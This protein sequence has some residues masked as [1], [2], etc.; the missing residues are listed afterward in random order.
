M[1]KDIVGH[2][3]GEPLTGTYWFKDTQICVARDTEGKSDGFF[4]AAKGGNNQES[5]NH[6][7][8]GSCI[9][10]YNALP[11]LIDAGVGTY[12]RQTFGPERYTIWTMQ[13]D[14]HNLPLINGTSQKN[15]REFAAHSQ[16]YK[17]TAKTVSYQ[18]DI[19]RAYPQEANVKAGFATIRCTGKG[20]HNHRQMGTFGMQRTECI[21]PDDLLRSRNRPQQKHYADR[22]G[23]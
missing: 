1:Y 23:R 4:F 20:F 16:Q 7:D 13:S 5:H 3:Q 8:V 14:Y 19:A 9:L 22:R 11:V 15:G 10:Y 12:T 6:N 18:V 17:A 21:K 2:P